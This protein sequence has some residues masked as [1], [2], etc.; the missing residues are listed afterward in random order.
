MGGDAF[1]GK[2]PI[3]SRFCNHE[4]VRFA[5]TRRKILQLRGGKKSTLFS[6]G[7]CCPHKTP[8]SGR[9]WQIEK[10]REVKYKP[11]AYMSPY[12]GTENLWNGTELLT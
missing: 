3:G 1:D 12:L 9:G 5:T 10:S 6:V 7:V 11:Q 4:E 8:M 2:L